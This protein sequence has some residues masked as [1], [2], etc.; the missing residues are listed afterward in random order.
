MGRRAHINLEDILDTARTVFFERGFDGATTADIAARAKVSE[1]SLFKRFKTKL[2]LFAAA[3]RLPVFDF[4]DRLPGLLAGR[5]P[6]EALVLLIKEASHLHDDMMPKL[7][8]L[9]AHRHIMKWP[10]PEDAPPFRILQMLTSYFAGEIKRGTIRPGKPEIYARI[11]MGAVQ[12]YFIM[13][14]LS[15]GRL[16]MPIEEFANDLVNH[17]W[18]GFAP[19]QV[20]GDS[21]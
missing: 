12:N 15:G 18:P 11:V 3:M 20:S 1:G 4:L 2:E 6:K 21:L 7:V 13:R 14:F 16:T 9:M 10:L 5:A 8:A 19:T 17:L